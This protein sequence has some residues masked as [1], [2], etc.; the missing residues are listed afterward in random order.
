M[1]NSQLTT[2]NSRTILIVTGE[3]SGDLHG[4][5]LARA[6]WKH[7]RSLEIL[8]MGGERMQKAGVKL[9]FDNRR[10]GVMGLVEVIRRFRVVAEAYRTICEQLNGGRIHLVI[11]IDSPDFNLRVAAVAKQKGIPAVYYIGPKVWAWRAGRVKAM[12]RLIHRILV[13]FPFEEDLYRQAGV[14]CRFVGHPLLDEIPR[15]LDP[16]QLR[17]QYGVDPKGTVVALLPGSRP[18]EVRRL[19]PV[20]LSA[21]VEV[22]AQVPGVAFLLPVAPSIKQEVVAEEVGRW[23][24]RVKLISGEAPGVLACSDAAIVASGTATLEAALVGTPMVII[25]K[26]AYLTYLVARML[27]K[28]RSVGLVNIVAGQRVV[29]ELL[30]GAAT[31]ERITKELM[32]LLMDERMRQ[33]TKQALSQVSRQLGPPGA[34]MRAAEEI[35]EILQEHGLV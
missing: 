24:L 31:A 25:Y 16:M 8:G 7:N 23:P 18:Q 33:K 2:H 17:Q 34:S 9:I 3:A 10:L 6:L 28:V 14:A 27:V 32:P 13:I 26:M 22:A 4:A 30:Q 21:A 20:M 11:L 35:L 15:D 19:L 29:P 12:A 5:E 1:T